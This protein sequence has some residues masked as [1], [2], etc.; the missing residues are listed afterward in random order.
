MNPY[1]L[2]VLNA[3]REWVL[4][5][6]NHQEAIDSVMAFGVIAPSDY[7]ERVE[8]LSRAESRLRVAVVD[9]ERSIP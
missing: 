5:D 6:R 4:A 9:W 8:A 7:N 2:E 1:E 3:A